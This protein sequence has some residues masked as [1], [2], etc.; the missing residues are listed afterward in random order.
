MAR[1]RRW[2][3]KDFLRF[4]LDNFDALYELFRLTKMAVAGDTEAEEQA[5]MHAAR[6]ISDERAK[7]EIAGS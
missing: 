5:K 7:R 1:E 3:V 4:V 2:R 6:I